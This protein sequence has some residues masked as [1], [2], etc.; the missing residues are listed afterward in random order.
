MKR[1]ISIFLALLI[2]TACGI[3]GQTPASGPESRRSSA[4]KVIPEP[5]SAEPV[6]PD[7]P[8]GSAQP[9]QGEEA[10]DLDA[11]ETPD[12]DGDQ[13][14]SWE[15]GPPENTELR[16]KMTR[17]G[18]AVQDWFYSAMPESCYNYYYLRY[19]GEDFILVVGVTDE[20]AVDDGLASW[21][22]EKWDRLVKEPACFSR[23]ELGELAE[24]IKKLDLGPAVKIDA[25]VQPS[26]SY[27]EIGVLVLLTPKN[28][29][30]PPPEDTSRWDEVPKEVEDLAGEYGIP[31]DLISYR[32][33]VF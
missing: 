1:C 22:G 4:A 16:N 27:E 9:F 11:G 30:A 6:E 19:D 31:M 2:L 10:P 5:S 21:T 33:P 26:D 15:D 8:V 12:P 18:N 3:G 25:F 13:E 7:P 23:T 32:P 20:A 29:E 28:P 14:P 24:A 17:L